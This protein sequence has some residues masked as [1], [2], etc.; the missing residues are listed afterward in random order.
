MYCS[1][2]VQLEYS[3]SK[4]PPQITNKHNGVNEVSFWLTWRQRLF[5]G[6]KLELPKLQDTVVFWQFHIILNDLRS[7]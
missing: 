5:P 7:N 3:P 1:A 2:T 6:E 4:W